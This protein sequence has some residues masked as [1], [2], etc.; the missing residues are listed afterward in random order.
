MFYDTHAHLNADQFKN[1]VTEIIEEARENQVNVINV[2]GF[3][4]K[5]NALANQIAL[6]YENVYA[7]AGFHPADISQFDES[8]FETL[9]SYLKQNITVAVGECGLDYYWHKETKNKQ[10]EYFKRQIELSKQYKKPLII[11]VRD[12]IADSYEVLKEASRHGHLKG[13]MH[14]FSGTP[15]MAKRFLDLGLYISL[16]GPVTFKNAKIPKEVAK[17]IPL[18]RLLVETDCPF[19]APHPY[20]GKLNKPAYV[21]IIAREIANLKKVS[22]EEIA[23][24]TTDNGKKLFL[25]NYKD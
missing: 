8:D 14:C 22:L 20:R 19:L 9:E 17:V 6:K 21:P 3:N 24:Y 18:D 1:Q 16:G 15:E 13:V 12:A 4:R 7:S 10:I 5:T 11:H 23:Y 2:V 25:T